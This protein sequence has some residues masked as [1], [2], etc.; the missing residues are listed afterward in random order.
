MAQ[1]ERR[2][3]WRI[4]ESSSGFLTAPGVSVPLPG[5]DP[6]PQPQAQQQVS[7][8]ALPQA[9]SSVPVTQFHFRWILKS[10][11]HTAPPSSP[12]Y[13][14]VAE[15]FCPLSL[16]IT[17]SATVP[18]PTRSLGGRSSISEPSLSWDEASEMS[19]PGS[20]MTTFLCLLL[21][22]RYFLRVSY[23]PAKMQ[24]PP[25]AAH[26]RRC[27]SCSRGSSD[28]PTLCFSLLSLVS[29]PHPLLTKLSLPCLWLLQLLLCK[30]CWDPRGKC[31]QHWGPFS[32]SF[33]KFTLCVWFGK[34]KWRTSH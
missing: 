29:G 18:A 10:R 25:R 28:P 13:C 15:F 33:R 32:C 23:T 34:I 4:W 9:P 5:A 21:A 14:N 17:P 7:L 16:C 6:R 12:P 22:A 31:G 26:P 2:G 20:Q 1:A 27:F 3:G 24:P 30:A 11:C 8:V 19:P